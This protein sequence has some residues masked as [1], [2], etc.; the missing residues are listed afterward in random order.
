MFRSN[1]ALI[2][3]IP[4]RKIRKILQSNLA[5]YQAKLCRHQLDSIVSA[6]DKWQKQRL[7]EEEN[8]AK[9]IP[10]HARKRW[11]DDAKARFDQRRPENAPKRHLCDFLVAF[12]CEKLEKVEDLRDKQVEF[13]THCSVTHT[14]SDRRALILNASK[15]LGSGRWRRF[16][17][18]R[19]LHRWLDED[20]IND[21]FARRVGATEL[22]LVFAFDQLGILVGE[23]LRQSH[24]DG[25]DVAP[26]W[27]R[28]GVESTFGRAIP[29]SMDT[30]VHIAAARCLRLSLCSLPTSVASSLLDETNIAWIGKA[31]TDDT[32]DVWLQCEALELLR[33]T[34][35]SACEYILKWRISDYEH[36]NTI[37]VRRRV[38]KI[39]IEHS[40]DTPLFDEAINAFQH[41]PSVFVRQQ[42]AE[43]LWSAPLRQ[44]EAHIWSLV[45]SDES[46]KVRAAG[47]VA[48]LRN[49]SEA[50]HQE[51]AQSIIEEVLKGE[52]DEFVLRTALHVLVNSCWHKANLADAKRELQATHN[53][54]DS[55]ALIPESLR[56]TLRKLSVSADSIPLRRWTSAAIARI[57]C[58]SCTRKRSLL[59]RL[60]TEVQK[61]KL[62]RTR[63]IRKSLSYGCNNED[64]GEV[65][66]VLA[67]DD[68]G[69][70]LERGWFRDR[71]TRGPVFGFRWWR[72]VLEL[73]RSATDKRQAFRHTIGR[74]TRGRI[75]APS[76]IMAELSPTKIPGRASLHCQRGIMA[77]LPSSAG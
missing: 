4:G 20:A 70:T 58:L 37:F 69:L 12:L 54:S 65:L 19:A 31:A 18:R 32:L 67:Q 50:S 47:L 27:Q 5:P 25:A 43:S 11:I 60:S 77:S 9:Q 23:M 34:S 2:P 71:V 63:A 8:L 42:F 46:P 21:R 22:E 29:K 33:N 76:Q 24:F 73:T 56:T 39:V 74:I 66:A 40:Y 64:I 62:G 41:D 68:F 3:E 7:E 59:N 17:D 52:R 45:T 53:E 28:I 13:Q 26:M 57:E 10:K 49:V 44:T 36:P 14:P 55:I 48:A 35:D 75:H 38:V 6:F 72:F 51:L 61:V 1:S 30:R 16:G 15:Q